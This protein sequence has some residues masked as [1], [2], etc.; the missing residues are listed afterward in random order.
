MTKKELVAKTAEKTGKSQK[1]VLEILDGALGVIADTLAEKED[2]RI[3]DF[4]VFKPL[5]RK[6]RMQRN[7]ATGE[8]FMSEEK[9]TVTFKPYDKFFYY[10]RR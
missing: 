10:G 8:M 4:G 1:D 9:E 6:P 5:T 3:P 7:P 2:V